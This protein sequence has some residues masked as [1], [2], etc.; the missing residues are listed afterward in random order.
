MADY[1]IEGSVSVKAVLNGG[2]RTVS[3]ILFDKD[4]KDRDLAF[5]LK[6]ARELGVN[7]LRAKDPI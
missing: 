4:R 1:I 5:I 7:I 6:K 3:E 2:R